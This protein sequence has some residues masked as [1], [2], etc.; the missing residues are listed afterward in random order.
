M[1]M[2][3]MAHPE[4]GSHLG[5]CHMQMTYSTLSLQGA[6]T[7]GTQQAQMDQGRSLLYT[8]PGDVH[9][10]E[11]SRPTAVSIAAAQDTAR[12]R[13]SCTVCIALL[14]GHQVRVKAAAGRWGARSSP[15]T[16]MGEA[17]P[18]RGIPLRPGPPDHDQ[19][20]SQNQVCS[21]C[22]LTERHQTGDSAAPFAVARVVVT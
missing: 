4:L 20:C 7:C 1:H 18:P 15:P 10:R 21:A 14:A 17:T 11:P 16:P 19:R 5:P 22:L 9:L 12:N 6:Y 8:Q 3:A 13:T 2:M